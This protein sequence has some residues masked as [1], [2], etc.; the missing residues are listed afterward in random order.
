MLPAPLPLPSPTSLPHVACPQDS[1]VVVSLNASI[2]AHRGA[3][4]SIREIGRAGAAV[5]VAAHVLC[6]APL[7]RRMLL[8][9][10]M[11]CSAPP[12]LRPG[13]GAVPA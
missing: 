2:G 8:H 5:L 9:A 1:L 6:D 7:C 12:R 13:Q 11:P 4:P 3:S 10:L